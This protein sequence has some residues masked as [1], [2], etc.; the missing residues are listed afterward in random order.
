[1]ESSLLN[2]EWIV[3]GDFNMVK[4]E[5]YWG[6]NVRT[7]VNISRKQAQSICKDTL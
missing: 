1:M 4:W 7:V 2:I 5:H 3:G 6:G